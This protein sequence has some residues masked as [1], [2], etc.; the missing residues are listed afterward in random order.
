M[1]WVRYEGGANP[2]GLSR[3]NRQDSRGHLST[4]H[5]NNFGRKE[6]SS[7]RWL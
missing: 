3:D 6:T 5:V 1:D 7:N 2:Y 4:W